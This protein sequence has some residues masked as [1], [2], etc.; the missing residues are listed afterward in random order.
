MVGRRVPWSAWVI[1]CALAVG[2]G[3]GGGSV[4][5]ATSLVE[6]FLGNLGAGRVEEAVALYDAR[7]FEVTSRLESEDI[8]RGL[9]DQLGAVSGFERTGWRLNYTA[10]GQRLQVILTYSVDR[11]KFDSTETFTVE[12]ARD[13][14]PRI[15]KHNIQSTGLSP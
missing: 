2:C 15:L 10:R 11:A 7:F 12:T 4:A 8:L 14:S 1:S 13:G 3:S 6:E 5:V 9:K